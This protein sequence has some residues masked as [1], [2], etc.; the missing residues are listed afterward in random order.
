MTE[1]KWASELKMSEK[2]FAA[3]IQTLVDLG[4]VK[5]FYNEYDKCFDVDI[6][7]SAL[8]E[9]YSTP[10]TEAKKAELLP[11]S[12]EITWNKNKNVK[13]APSKIDITS[14]SDEDIKRTWLMLGALMNERKETEK[15]VKSSEKDDLPFND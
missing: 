7:E 14:M 6:V 12:T 10:L 4:F 5:I 15:L 9:R 3:S 1:S 8:S 13:K 2:N 11:V